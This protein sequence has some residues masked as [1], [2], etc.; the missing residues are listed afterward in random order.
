MEEML[1]QRDAHIRDLEAELAR[2]RA[3]MAGDSDLIRQLR[4]RVAELEAR[5]AELE[6]TLADANWQIEFLNKALA[7]KQQEMDMA[8]AS[9]T[10]ELAAERRKVRTLTLSLSHWQQ[11]SRKWTW[12]LPVSTTSSLRKEWDGRHPLRPQPLRKALIPV[13]AGQL[14]RA[15][16][17]RSRKVHARAHTHTHTHRRQA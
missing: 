2:M 11:N 6:K 3:L 4:D 14:A 1:A 13:E 10:D 17:R 5:V 16:A 9:L 12:L 7:A 15:A 8:V